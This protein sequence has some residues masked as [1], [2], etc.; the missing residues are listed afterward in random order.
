MFD[1]GRDRCARPVS[2]GEGNPHADPVAGED[3]R[4]AAGCDQAE[5][6]SVL[7]THSGTQL[8]QHEGDNGLPYSQR[9]QAHRTGDGR[10]FGTSDSGFSFMNFGIQYCAK[11]KGCGVCYKVVFVDLRAA[12]ASVCIVLGCAKFRRAHAERRFRGATN[13]RLA[14]VPQIDRRLGEGL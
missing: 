14:E 12:I 6:V 8:V 9:V 11:Q 3:G 5:S 4:T 2:V 13:L 7:R 10:L 1:Q